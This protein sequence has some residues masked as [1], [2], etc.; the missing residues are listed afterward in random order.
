MI[1]L[2]LFK[3]KLFIHLVGE[4]GSGKS[5]LIKIIS[6]VEKPEKGA[7]IIIDGQRENNGSCIGSYYIA[8][9]FKRFEPSGSYCFCD[10][11]PV[12][13]YPHNGDVFKSFY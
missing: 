8:V 5:T 9:Y 1:S 11:F 4:N 13:D 6:G 3:I 12:G 7:E 2:S 10:N